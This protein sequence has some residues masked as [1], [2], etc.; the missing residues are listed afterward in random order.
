MNC[1]PHLFDARIART[2][3]AVIAITIQVVLNDASDK[4][5]ELHNS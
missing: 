4:A 2:Q 5:K 3:L 1:M